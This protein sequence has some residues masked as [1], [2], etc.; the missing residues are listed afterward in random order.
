MID[1]FNINNIFDLN[2]YD[3]KKYLLPNSIK[4]YNILK[5][6]Y[7]EKTLLPLNFF[8]KEIVLIYKKTKNLNMYFDYTKNINDADIIIYEDISEFEN[9]NQL[10]QLRKDKIVIDNKDLDENYLNKIIILYRYFLNSR[11]VSEI[12]KY[13]NF[14]YEYK[15]INLNFETEYF[16]EKEKL[17]ILKR[18]NTKVYN[19]NDIILDFNQKV[20]YCKNKIIIYKIDNNTDKEFIIFCKFDQNIKLNLLDILDKSVS[21]NKVIGYN[22]D[23]IDIKNFVKYKVIPI[24]INTTIPV[25][26]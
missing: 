9:F 6:K 20:S 21:E 16:F 15:E 2:N 4:L 17:Y 25:M 24:G 8:N 26:K 7:Y 23:E 12:E 13:V 22:N 10:E 5:E 14:N 3:G 1:I 19:L 11:Y 18:K